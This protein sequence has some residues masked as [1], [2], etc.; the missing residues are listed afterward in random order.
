MFMRSSLQKQKTKSPTKTKDTMKTIKTTKLIHLCAMAACLAVYSATAAQAAATNIPINNYSFENATGYWA[1][2]NGTS[3]WPR[4]GSTLTT[5]GSYNVSVTNGLAANF[6][7]GGYD[8]ANS[9]I[10]HVD[11]GAGGVTGTAWAATSTLGTYA[12]NTVYTLTVAVAQ[13]FINDASRSSTIA[14]GTNGADIGTALASKTT[15]NTAFGSTHA[16]QDITL[17]LDTSVVTAAVGQ[18]IALFLGN[19]V[20]AGSY[21][22]DNLYYDNVRLTSLAVVTDPYTLWSAGIANS[23]DRDPT[24]DPDGDGLTNLQEYLFGTSPVAGNGSLTTFQSTPGGLI[25]RWCQRA[26]GTYTLQ[27]SATLAAD[28]WTTSAV[29]PV[30]AA[31]QTGLY[32][33]DYTRMEATI[34][35]S[36]THDFVRVQAQ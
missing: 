11:T 3:S 36:G 26:S 5:G 13:Q 30:V 33:A 32:S 20:S 22:G 34:P 9:M 10:V 4:V 8:G 21:N 17:T 14:F 6:T 2:A 31:D 1:E 23:A 28:S 16:F 24:A 15:L 27:E 25:V 35:V 19:T 12:A 18:N 29:V 7:G